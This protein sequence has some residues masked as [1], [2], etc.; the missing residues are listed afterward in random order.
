MKREFERIM[1]SPMLR[2]EWRMQG[3]LTGREPFREIVVTRFK[4][5]C[6]ADSWRTR[7]GGVAGSGGVG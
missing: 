1:L 4:G 5:Y 2:I 7:W 3:D 6:Q